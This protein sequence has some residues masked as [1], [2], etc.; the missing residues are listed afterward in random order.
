[1]SFVYDR[2]PIAA[3]RTWQRSIPSP[4][5]IDQ[6]IRRDPARW[7]TLV[8]DVGDLFFQ[9]AQDTTDIAS[10]CGIAE[11]TAYSALIAYRQRKERAL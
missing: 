10:I 4:I 3:E 8:D 9:H 11:S 6:E 5:T 2:D 7:A 1:M